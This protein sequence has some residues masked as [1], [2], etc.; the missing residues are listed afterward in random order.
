MQKRVLAALPIQKYRCAVENVAALR[1]SIVAL[2]RH[3][4]QQEVTNMKK[5]M[6]WSL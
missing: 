3:L 6:E 4:K 5:M 2:G 1:R